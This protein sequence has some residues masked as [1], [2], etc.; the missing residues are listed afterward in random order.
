VV[1]RH[2][3]KAVAAARSAASA[4]AGP[5]TGARAYDSPVLGSTVSLVWPV[6]AA[7][8]LPLT[9]LLSCKVLGTGE[10]TISTVTDNSTVHK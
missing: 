4:S 10:A 6:A 5:E 2:P 1:S 8:C 9:K 7:A 3:S